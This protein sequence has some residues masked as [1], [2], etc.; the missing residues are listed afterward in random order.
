MLNLF[1]QTYTVESNGAS[2]LFTIYLLVVLAA[3]VVSIIGLWKMFEKAG[4]P[5]WAAIIPIYN[6]Y[7]L[8]K[9]SGRPE[10]WLLLY[11][12]PFVNIVVSLLIALDVGKRFGQSDVFSIIMLW[13]FSS[14]GYVILGFGDAEYRPTA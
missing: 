11:F 12:I 4:Q 1:A 5:G 6:L 13:L 8:V 14:L 2:G 10:W 7:I 9:I 3:V